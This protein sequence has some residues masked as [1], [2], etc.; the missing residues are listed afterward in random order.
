MTAGD[1][2]EREYDDRVIEG[3]FDSPGNTTDQGVTG[4]RGLVEK[5]DAG[6]WWYDGR[7]TEGM[8]HWSP[9]RDSLTKSEASGL[10]DRLE[11][12]GS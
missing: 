3:V 1:Y 8:L 12:L 10:I 11:K 5:A 9:L 2:P 4:L 7:D 6:P